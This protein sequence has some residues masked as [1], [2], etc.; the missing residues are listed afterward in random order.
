MICATCGAPAEVAYKYELTGAGFG[1]SGT[2]CIVEMARVQCST[3][4]F[5]DEELSSVEMEP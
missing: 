4:H 2:E 3:G 5:Y 1:P